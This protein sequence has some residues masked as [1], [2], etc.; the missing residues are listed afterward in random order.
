MFTY[1]IVQH[2]DILINYD[3]KIFFNGVFYR[4][5]HLQKSRHCHVVLIII[6]FTVPVTYVQKYKSHHTEWQNDLIYS[7]IIV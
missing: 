4:L 7:F 5:F 3:L 1:I 6:F 2:G